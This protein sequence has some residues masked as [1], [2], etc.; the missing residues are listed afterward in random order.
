MLEDT[1]SLDAAQIIF[2]MQV[3]LCGLINTL[4]QIKIV[5]AVHISRKTCNMST[6]YIELG[7][8]LVT[9]INGLLL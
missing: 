5:Q 9:L 4:R 8:L 3:L 7:G 6:V 1:N 2:Q